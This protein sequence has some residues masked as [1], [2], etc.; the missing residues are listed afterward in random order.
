MTGLK[1]ISPSPA[2]VDILDD[3]A[4]AHRILEMEDHGDMSMGHLSFRDPEG[5][6]A[7]LKRG[8]LGF[9]E[10]QPGDFILIDWDGN[11]LEGTGLRHLEWPLHTEM[12][13]ARPDINVVGHSHPFNAIILSATG[14]SLR[15]YSNEGVWFEEHGVPHFTLTSNL[16]DTRAL[17]E[18][19]AASLG[20]SDAV[21]LRN[22]GASFVGTGVKECTLAGIF[23]E[24]A[25]KMQV[26][27]ASTGWKHDAPDHDEILTK[28]V[29]IYPERAKNNFWNYFNRKLAVRE[30]RSWDP[31]YDAPMA[32]TT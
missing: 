24:K 17:G 8:N 19:H 12:M 18:A 21:L 20:G 30:G 22:H 13:L 16:I 14:Q 6:G 26:A 10:V 11:V 3:L 25:A 27:I 32:K 2:V 28:R 7:W 23:L 9:E 29:D 1:P 4:R 5:R 31:K 15:A